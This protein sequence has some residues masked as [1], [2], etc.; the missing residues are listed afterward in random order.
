MGGIFV[1]TVAFTCATTCIAMA[2]DL[3]RGLFDR[4]RSLPMS[5]SAVLAGRTFADLAFAGVT[6]AAMALTGLLV[7]WRTDASAVSV[8]G[9][10]AL[11]ALFAYSFLWIGAVIGLSVRSVEVAQTAGLIWL[12]PLTFL[13]NAF[14][15]LE[16]MPTWLQPIAAWNPISAVAAAVRELFGNVPPG[17]QA[18]DY[19]PLQNPVLAS[20]AVVPGP[21]GG[22]RARWAWPGTAGPRRADGQAP[23]PAAGITSG[24][25]GTVVTVSRRTR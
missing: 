2:D 9:G 4:F 11:L 15:P 17:Y 25:S 3:S 18:P 16:T 13:S 23:G 14:V 22:L 8:L 20:V 6:T 1:Q 24:S 7:G 21:A 10:F 12:F 19:W 5:R